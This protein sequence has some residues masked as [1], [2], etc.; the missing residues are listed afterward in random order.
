MMTVLVLIG[1]EKASTM[2]AGLP[3]AQNI[4]FPRSSTSTTNFWRN[5]LEYSSLS[6]SFAAM[7]LAVLVL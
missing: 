2:E 3:G 4:Y 1:F 6:L 7:N 5:W